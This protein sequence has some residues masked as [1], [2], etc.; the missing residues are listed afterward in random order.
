MIFE[1][2]Q[3]LTTPTQIEQA[4][5]MG[6]LKEAIAMAARADRCQHEW[7]EHY[8]HCKKVINQAI[9]RAVQH[10]TALIF[11][12]GSLKDVP[13]DALSKQFEKVLLVDL[14][15]LKEARHKA[16]KFNNVELIEHDVTE[17]LAWIS[18]G[19]DWVQAPST[20][21]DDTHIDLVVSLNLITQL[22]LIPVRW[23]LNDFKVPEATADIVGKQL[24][25]AHVNY[26]KQFSGEVCLI[27]D[28]LDIEFD[29]KGNEVERFDPWWDVE[30]PK[31]E[32]SWEWEVVP[33]GEAGKKWQKNHVGVSFV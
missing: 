24:I 31:P 13:L 7:G 18:E 32:V 15:F 12:A 2:W 27:A 14:V 9:Y 28:Y 6:Y 3:Y 10:R 4:K 19:Q 21:L 29:S 17:S 30:P 26:L 25:F 16:D 5:K 22:P 1:F 8:Q 11:G 23:L 20:W 33:L